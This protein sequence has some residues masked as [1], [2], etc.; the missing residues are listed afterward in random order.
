MDSQK[1]SRVANLIKQNEGQTNAKVQKYANI[2][3]ANTAISTKVCKQTQFNAETKTIA[4]ENATKQNSKA[5]SSEENA[6]NKTKVN[7]IKHAR[8]DKLKR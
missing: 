3:E 5:C 7:K 8:P 4:Y 1:T 2:K 6:K